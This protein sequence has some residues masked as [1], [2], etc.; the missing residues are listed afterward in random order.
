[1]GGIRYHPPPSWVVPRPRCPI[2]TVLILVHYSY[3]LSYLDCPPNAPRRLPLTDSSLPPLPVCSSDALATYPRVRSSSH[4]EPCHP[5]PHWRTTEVRSYS[6][7]V[8]AASMASFLSGYRSK[9]LLKVLSVIPERA[10]SLS[11]GSPSD[12]ASRT[13]DQ[14]ASAIVLGSGPFFLGASEGRFMGTFPFPP[15][16]RTSPPFAFMPQLTPRKGHF[17]TFTEIL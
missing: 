9:Y 16:T 1:M 2:T 17:A 6:P 15:F 4:A 12:A 14:S 5:L 13:R 10:Q 11:I 3:C 8:L 7:R